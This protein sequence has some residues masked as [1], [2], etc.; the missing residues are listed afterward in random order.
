MTFTEAAVEVLRRS[1]KPLHYKQIAQEAIA[2]GL[3]SHVGQTPE[4]T[5]GARLLAMS[6]SEQDRAVIAVDTGTFGL[7]EW[8]LPATPEPALEVPEPQA[9]KERPYRGRERHPP[10]GEEMTPSGRRDDRRRRDEGDDGRR[11]KRYAPP[12]DVAHAW[13]REHGQPVTLE[14]LARA[15]REKDRIAEALERDLGSFEKALREENRRREGARRTPIFEFLEGGLVRGLDI[16]KEL[17][18]GRRAEKPPETRQQAP[19]EEVRPAAFEEQRRVVLR[20]V[21]R[22]VSSL[23]MAALERLAV[24]LLEAQGFRELQMARRTKEGPIYLARRKWGAS[25]WRFVVRVLKPGRDLGR[26]EVQ[27]LRKEVGHFSAQTGIVF[28]AAEC[29]REAKSE[30][31]SPQAAPVMLYGAEALAEALVDAGLGARKRL[32]EWLDYDEAFF[33]SI[34]AGDEPPDLPPVTEPLE[35]VKPSA[36]EPRET[37]EKPRRG[38][39]RERRRGDRRREEPSAGLPEATA[40]EAVPESTEA[41][42]TEVSLAGDAGAAE[43]WAPAAGLPARPVVEA[44]ESATPE[45]APTEAAPGMVRVDA[46]LD[47][48][49]TPA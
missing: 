42:P 10:M 16:P 29:S 17:P 43:P 8:G 26:P 32:V 36:E 37:E 25:E 15:L 33:A 12:S 41:P 27:E 22:R 9:E 20:T 14:S 30:G 47:E 6:G 45:A 19:R 21:R 35:P 2:A 46:A 28:G 5:M 18:Q 40:A 39:D 13:L 23:D 11:K 1:G 7:V 4:E 3:L 49:V 38:R 34:G 31:N 44:V 24:A 48:S